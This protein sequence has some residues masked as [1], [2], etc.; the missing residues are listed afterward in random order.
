MAHEELLPSSP[1]GLRG[2]G[3]PDQSG[4]A[5]QPHPRRPAAGPGRCR[6]LLELRQRPQ[7]G[8]RPSLR[9]RPCDEFPHRGGIQEG[10]IAG[11][12]RSG[13][14]LLSRSPDS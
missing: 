13:S 5:V 9:L 7:S 10:L 6:S 12:A 1:G 14:C 3:A 2:A 11:R 8:A 4:H